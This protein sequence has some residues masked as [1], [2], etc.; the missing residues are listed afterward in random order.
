MSVQLYTVKQ[1]LRNETI[2]FKSDFFIQKSWGKELTVSIW[3]TR[4]IKHFDEKAK[5]VNVVISPLNVAA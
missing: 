1:A 3:W 2:V 4:A 5:L